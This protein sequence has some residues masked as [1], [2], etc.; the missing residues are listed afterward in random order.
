MLVA[1]YTIFVLGG[2]FSLGISDLIDELENSTKI[3]VV[4]EDRQKAALGTIKE[5]ENRIKEH[6]KSVKEISKALGK[7]LAEYTLQSNEI[8]KLWDQY[9]DLS[10]DVTRDVIELR[11]QY[12]DQL[13][14]DEWDQVFVE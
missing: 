2:G 7:E 3:V 9:I 14:R 4:D 8:D 5:M 12:R 10:S 1:L 6:N 13:T 11:F